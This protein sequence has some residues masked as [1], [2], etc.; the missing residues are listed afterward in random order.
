[1]Y[2]CALVYHYIKYMDTL[3]LDIVLMKRSEKYTV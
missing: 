1:M 2:I 3:Y